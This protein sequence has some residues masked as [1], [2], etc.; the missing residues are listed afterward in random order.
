MKEADDLRQQ[1]ET[2]E[3]EWDELDV[4]IA[5]VKKELKSVNQQK[6]ELLK[7]QQLE[8]E[9]LKTEKLATQD[10]VQRELGTLKLAKELFAAEMEFEKSSIAEKAQSERSQMLLD[11]E[12]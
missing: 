2:F 6:E 11:F 12:L 7:L 3:R 8:E 5:D 4:K 9:K 1:K 10:Y